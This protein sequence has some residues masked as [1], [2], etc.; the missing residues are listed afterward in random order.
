MM[1]KMMIMG[2]KLLLDARVPKILHLI[3][4]SSWKVLC[5][6]R[7]SAPIFAQTHMK[8]ANI[9]YTYEHDGYD[10]ED[11]FCV[12]YIIYI[13]LFPR[14]LWSS[15]MRAASWGEKLPRFKSGLR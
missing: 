10:I 8:H 7:P 3:I 1:M 9:N 14:M 5:Y 4:C 6:L 2:Y 11:P 13:N 12:R 15:M